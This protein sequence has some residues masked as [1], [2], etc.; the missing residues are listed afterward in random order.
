MIQNYIIN[1]GNTSNI[2]NIGNTY[3]IAIQASFVLIIYL[4][5]G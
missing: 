5:I 2:S 1:I 4:T 3:N